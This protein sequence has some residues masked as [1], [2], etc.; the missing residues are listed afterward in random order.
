MGRKT[1]PAPGSVVSSRFLRRLGKRKDALCYKILVGGIAATRAAQ[2]LP[3]KATPKLYL[4]YAVG[5]TKTG[6]LKQQRV[7]RTVVGERF[8]C[9]GNARVVSGLCE[10]GRAEGD[11]SVGEWALGRSFD[12]PGEV[13]SLARVCQS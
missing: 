6:L 13:S 11:A 12:F 4:D 3:Q 9:P 2:S 10:V 8:A 7:W 5:A 1:L